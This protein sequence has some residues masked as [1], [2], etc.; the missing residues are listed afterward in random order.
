MRLI[1]GARP[2]FDTGEGTYPSISGTHNG[3]IKTN[4]TINVNKLYTYPCPGT[5]GHTEYVRIWNSSWEGI[6][7]RWKGYLGDWH[8]I[9]F[10]QSF[11]LIKNETYNYTVRTGSYPQIIHEQ[12]HITSDGSLITCEEFIDANGKKYDDWIPAIKLLYSR[13]ED[14]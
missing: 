13:G 9:S 1:Q 6:E 11:M 14:A 4:Q 5:G 8:N 12:K 3:T 7:A 10:N 2:V